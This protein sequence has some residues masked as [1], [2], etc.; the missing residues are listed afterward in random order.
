V[1]VGIGFDV[2]PLV[3]GKRLVLGGIEVPCGKGLHGHSDA[4]VLLHAIIDALLGA[5]GLGDIGA[6]FGTADP[7]YKDASSL[8]FLKAAWERISAKGFVVGNIDATIVAEAPELAPFRERMRQTIA[9]SLE[10]PLERINVKASSA[11][12]QGFVG[13]GEGIAAFAVASLDLKAED[14]R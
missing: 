6:H 5:A 13:R 12:G 3:E 10:I 4:D 11:N 2:H 9:H 14:R 8:L 7:R 1:R